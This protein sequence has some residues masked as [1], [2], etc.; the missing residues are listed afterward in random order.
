MNN[1]LPRILL[2]VF[3]V[4]FEASDLLQAAERSVADV[5]KR[6]NIVFFLADDQRN[7]QLGCY[8]HPFVKTPNLDKLAARGTRFTNAFVTTSICA[9]SRATIFT[10]MVE[11]SHHYT[12]GTPAINQDFVTHS[13]PVVMKNAGY[14]TGFVGKFGVGFSGGTNQAFNFFHPINR[15][16]YFKEQPDGS[17]RHTTQLSGD[18]AIEFI[19]ANKDEPFMLSVSFNATHAEDNDK[20]DHFPWPKVMDGMYEDIKIPA[21]RL[22]ASEIFASQPEF[23][24]SSLNRERFFW[25]WDTPE[26]YEKNIRSYY[27]MLSGIDHVVGRVVDTL[28]E[29]GLDENTIVIYTGDNGYYMAQRG[30]AG[31]WSHYEE[32]LRVPMIITDPRVDGNAKGQVRDEVVLNLDLASTFVSAGGINQPRQ[33]QGEDLTGLVAGKVPRNWR[34]DFFCEHLMDVPGR[35]PKWEGVREQRWVYANYFQD[36]YEFLHDLEADPDQLTNLAVDPK[37]KAQLQKMRKRCIELRDSYGGEYSYE[38]VPTNSYLRKQAEEAKKQQPKP[39]PAVKAKPKAKSQLPENPNVVLIISDDQAWTDYSFMAHPV[40]K[41]PRLDQLASESATFTRGYVPQALCRSSL[42]TLVSGLY[43]RHH[44]ITGNDPTPL[45]KEAKPGE[46]QQ[47]RNQLIAKIDQ[48]DTVPRMLQAKG[49][50]SHQ[51]GKWWEGH[52]SRGGFTHGM[53][54]GDPKRGGR[55]GDVGLQIG[56]QG[57]DPVLNFIKQA[58]AQE[59]PFF[60]WYAPFLPHTPHNPPERLL[61]RYTAE[62]RPLQ[63]AKYYAMCEWFD[64]TCGQLLDIIDNQGLRKDTVVIYVTDNGWI[65]RTPD[66]DLGPAWR[67][68]YA[69]RSKQ[70]VNE[71]GIRTPV[72]VR[73]PGQVRPGKRNQLVSS[74][75]IAPTILELAGLEKTE[76]MDGKNLIDV[77]QGRTAP[78][79]ALFGESYAH[80][81]ADLNDHTK[82]L[83]YRYVIKGDWKLLLSYEGVVN[84]YKWSHPERDSGPQL[85]N[86]RVDPAETDNRA[87]ANPEI[88][89]QLTE[90]LYN[91]W[92]HRKK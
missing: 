34:T 84:R 11:R 69:P 54:H 67:S 39:I 48:I 7:D 33:Y 10:G 83:L 9:A 43:P 18:A 70:S 59:K 88:V 23:L 2:C 64:E 80:D 40:I 13:Y 6:P 78:H 15:S 51:S 42:A 58:K 36:D 37:F 62:G 50:L 52:Y 89:K 41:T 35:I 12:F 72:M 3:A 8:G 82:T 56:R 87:A 66:M 1:Y 19:K 63:L 76:R 75:D 16:K 53:T 27:R 46:Y 92:D 20:V 73:W 5:A 91:H 81:I 47:L 25:R 26:K 14:K 28:E 61:S 44:Q 17:H 22:N 90:L 57:M 32:S 71:G 31:K 49:Y 68:S 21:P 65:Q 55:H 86:L 77:A 60:I 38:L 79:Q 30:F 74:I 24:R 29:L 85:Y 45:G 4:W